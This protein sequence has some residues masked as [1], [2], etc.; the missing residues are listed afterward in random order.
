M[1]RTLRLA[2]A[3]GLVVAPSALAGQGGDSLLGAWFSE[4]TYRPVLHGELTLARQGGGWRASLA[5]AEATFAAAGD[6]LRFAFPDSG[7]GFRGAMEG[8][9]IRGFWLRPAREIDGQA[10]ASPLVLRRAGEGVWRG[11][12]QPLDDRFTLQLHVFRDSAGTLLAA[13]RNPQRNLRGRASQFTVI[14]GPDSIRFTVRPDTTRPPE[15]WLTAVHLRDPER[16]RIY[17][18]ER[19]QTVELTRATPA[20]LAASFPRPHDQLPYVYRQPDALDDGW[21]TARAAE[22]GIDEAALARAVQSVAT[23][24]PSERRP[25]LAHSLLVAHRG[26]LVLEEYFFGHGRDTPHDVRSAGKTFGSVMLGAAMMEGVEVSPETPIYT[27]LAERGPFANPDPRK[28]GITL[29]HLMT[30]TAGLACNDNDDDSP[31]N[32]GTMQSQTEQPDWWKYTLDLPMAHDPGSRYAYCSAN[33]NLIGA[34]LTVGTDTW[35]PALF[36]RTVARPLQFGPYHWNLTPTGEGYL[37]GGAY[38]RP[39]DLLKIGQAFLDGGVWNG[40]RIVD[41]VWVGISTAPRVEISPATTGLS[42][43][44]FGNFYGAG[45]DGYAWHLNSLTSGGR[46]WTGYEASGNGGQLLIVMPELDLVVV[47]TGGNYGQG[48]IWGRWRQ[49]IIGD[50]IVPAIRG[51]SN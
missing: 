34:A 32:E 19:R 20:Q 2:L 30:H 3:A 6:S 10:F 43:D 41:S 4:T 22:V 18:P 15:V 44:D 38:L 42:P 16:I 31:G 1:I 26:R 17:W 11:T 27:L 33:S 45:M 5:G 47:F 7:G 40:R 29:A 9:S 48:G 36:D 39:R 24:S 50:I 8:D 37:G 23:R 12:V 14:P 49:E 51:T 13:F 28:A 21:R 46:T 35:L 25:A